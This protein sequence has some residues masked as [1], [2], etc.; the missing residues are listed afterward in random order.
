MGQVRRK[1][2]QKT[3]KR[4]PAFQCRY[5]AG[6]AIGPGNMFLRRH[7]PVLVVI[8]AA[9]PADAEVTPGARVYWAAYICAASREFSFCK[10]II[11]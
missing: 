2:F 8:V 11:R 6:P 5:P 10:I 1:N 7:A 4:Q 9:A 3:L